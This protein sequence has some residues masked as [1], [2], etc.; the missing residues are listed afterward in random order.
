MIFSLDGVEQFDDMLYLRE[1]VEYPSRCDGMVVGRVDQSQGVSEC[2]RMFLNEG[3][4]GRHDHRCVPH[5]FAK[6]VLLF[7]TSKKK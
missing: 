6:L 4:L 3:E 7:D 2:T 1:I 5:I